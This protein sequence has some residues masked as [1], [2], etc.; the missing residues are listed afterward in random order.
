MLTGIIVILTILIVSFIVQKKSFPI[1]IV[2]GTKV[3]TVEQVK[4][5]FLAK[6]PD[7]VLI[8][9]P[10]D[11]DLIHDDKLKSFVTGNAVF[12]RDKVLYFEWRGGPTDQLEGVMV[13]DLETKNKRYVVSLKSTHGSTM[14]HKQVFIIPRTYEVEISK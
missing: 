2:D 10:N 11:V 9:V 13:S 1:P 4:D 12:G 6:M 3:N 5:P 14:S 8:A 7:P